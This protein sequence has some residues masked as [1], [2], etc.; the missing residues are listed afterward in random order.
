MRAE[1]LESYAVFRRILG[2]T[3]PYWR[4]I[5]LSMVFAV[6][7]SVLSGVSLYL[8]IPLLDILFNPGKGA[9]AAAA[10][11]GE[12]FVAG[13]GA[14]FTALKNDLIAAVLAGAQTDALLRISVIIIFAYLLKNI[15]GYLQFFLMNFSE[16]SI[17]R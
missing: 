1:F 13:L 10:A 7:Y 6:F 15:F 5:S 11:G 16:E 8:F 12:G 17:I 9:S 14:W 4:Q 2:L 3:R